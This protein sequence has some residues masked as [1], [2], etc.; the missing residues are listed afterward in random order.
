M[1][2]GPFLVSS[3]TIGVIAQRL[4]RRLCQQC[5]ERYD[6]DPETRRYFGLPED[7]SLYRARGCA[8]CGGKGL[9][10]RVGIYE[11]MRMSPPLR[12]L[13]ARGA[14]ADELH[15]AAVAA[16]MVD[17]KAYS[18]RLLAAGLTSIEEVA[19]VVSLQES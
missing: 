12:R 6:P 19:S 5:R 10:G 1:G 13:V 14:E 8:D 3:S 16:G 11:V 15:A 2:I 18:A 7:A 4:A 17:L 9:K